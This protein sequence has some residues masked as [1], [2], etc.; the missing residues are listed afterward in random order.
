MS[1]EV[2]MDALTSDAK[3]WDTIA[4]RL[5]TSAN[6][7]AGLTLNP[8]AW[9]FAG[10]EA[11]E[12]YERF[13]GIVES[14]VRGGATETASA[15]VRLREIRRIYESADEEAKNDLARIWKWK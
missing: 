1:F 5:E 9:T 14:Y 12:A 6:D 3:R 13:R 2:A 4:G 15:A 10:G 7:L 11:A 8:K